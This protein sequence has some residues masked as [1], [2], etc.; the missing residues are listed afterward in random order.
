MYWSWNKSVDGQTSSCI[1]QVCLG[2]EGS[3][4]DVRISN[5]LQHGCCG[6][7]KRVIASCSD[8]RTIRLWDVSNV[9][10]NFGGGEAM[11][12][13]GETQRNRHT[14]FSIAATELPSDNSNCLAI[15]WGHTSRVWRVRFLDS[16]PCDGSLCLLSAGKDA[17]SRTWELVDSTGKAG[18]LPYVLQQTDCAAY[19][20]GKNMWSMTTY[21]QTASSIRVACGAADSKLTSHPL[22]G[23]DK[24]VGG[25]GNTTAEYS[26]QDLLHM[27]QP[28]VTA[29]ET[30][31]SGK[32]LKADSIRSY[33]F[34]LDKTLLLITNFGKILI[35]SF[36]SDASPTLQRNLTVSTLVDQL[37]ELSGYSVCASVSAYGTAFLA[38]TKGGI[39]MY[40]AI[41]S[42]LRIVHTVI[43]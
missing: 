18:T 10:V 31:E 23:T 7:L 28:S 29:E 11:V 24:Y 35:K 12:A 4:F 33:C 27:V 15:G 1:H 39:Y 26:V 3:I 30:R 42:S 19:H 36:G 32:A 16:S 40:R 37:E 43:G 20:D 13:S 5:E 17:T 38:S 34:I 6:N 8:D 21:R 9:N 14:G 22:L 25:K 41:D 2:H